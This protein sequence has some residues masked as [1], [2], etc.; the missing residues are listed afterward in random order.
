M[1]INTNFNVNDDVAF[2]TNWTTL[3]KM[4]GRDGGQHSITVLKELFYEKNDTELFYVI[5]KIVKIRIYIDK[6]ETAIKYSLAFDKRYNLSNIIINENELTPV[7]ETLPN[8]EIKNYLI[9]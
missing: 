6:K 5:G 1:E 9:K 4:G 8:F 3:E 2:L 7:K